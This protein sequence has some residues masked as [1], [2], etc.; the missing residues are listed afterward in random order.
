MPGLFL[1][2]GTD[3]G[4]LR[5]WHASYDADELL[6]AFAARPDLGCQAAVLFSQASE[7]TAALNAN[8]ADPLRCP[9]PWGKDFRNLPQRRIAR[10]LLA[11]MD[12]L[13]VSNRHADAVPLPADEEDA[14]PATTE[15]LGG[16]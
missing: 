11:I 4:W 15:P 7:V 13:G 14:A 16:L 8:R 1:N 5:S 3:E 12:E 6:A 9:D 10:R 2:V